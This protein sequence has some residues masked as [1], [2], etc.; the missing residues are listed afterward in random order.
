MISNTL[1]HL[2]VV[3]PACGAAVVALVRFIIM[4]PRVYREAR[5]SVGTRMRAGTGKHKPDLGCRL[6]WDS[7]RCLASDFATTE[8]FLSMMLREQSTAPSPSARLVVDGTHAY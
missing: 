4:L 5:T 7:H 2:R 1:I 6:G 3:A 8:R